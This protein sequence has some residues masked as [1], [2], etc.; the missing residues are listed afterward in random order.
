MI[1]WIYDSSKT[2]H[3]A[4]DGLC[5]EDVTGYCCGGDMADPPMDVPNAAKMYVMDWYALSDAQQEAIG[6]QIL[7]F[8]ASGGRWLPQW[9]A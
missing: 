8:D 6:S 2:M 9:K 5:G 1:T 4:G 3:H 7:M